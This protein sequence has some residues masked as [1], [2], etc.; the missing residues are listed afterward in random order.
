M[1]KRRVCRQVLLFQR[2]PQSVSSRRFIAVGLFLVLFWSLEGSALT[3]GRTQSFSGSIEGTVTDVAGLPISNATVYVLQIGRSPATTTDEDGKFL[4]ANVE[5]GQRRV[6]AYKESDNY[7]NPVWSFYGDANS[8]AGYPLV[9]V[10]QNE[11][12]R[13]VMVRLHT[14]ASRLV[15]KVI[16]SKTKQPLSH[17]AISLNHEGKPK[18]LFSPGSTNRDGELA[19]LIPSGVRINLKITAA[20][21]QPL[22]YSDRTSS[23]GTQAIQLKSG[24]DRSIKVELTRTQAGRNR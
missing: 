18:T 9:D 7:P 2:W 3:V 14:R 19:I 12:S 24:E 23:K 15:V 22:L 16:D 6:F 4:L 5:A 17:A 8:D 10:R 1:M 13:G 11:V 21:Y 20:G